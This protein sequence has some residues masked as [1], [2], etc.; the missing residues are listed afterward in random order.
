MTPLRKPSA[1]AMHHTTNN[2]HHT[3]N[4]LLR[5]GNVTG[6]VHASFS[7][8]HIVATLLEH[9]ATLDNLID[10]AARVESQRD[11]ALAQMVGVQGENRI[12]KV[13]VLALA[14]KVEHLRG[15]PRPRQDFTQMLE[16]I[17]QTM[18]G[19]VESL[20]RWRGSLMESPEMQ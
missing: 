7:L 19:I 20:R 8:E 10:D 16:G 1:P 2:K 4:M 13:Q 17:A 11:A 12:L 14:Q 18:E 5:S 9:I 3:T 15:N 6:L